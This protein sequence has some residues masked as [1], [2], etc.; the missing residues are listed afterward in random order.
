M[1]KDNKMFKE[2][3][4]NWPNLVTGI[5]LIIIPFYIASLI[6]EKKYTLVLFLIILFGD[7]LDGYLARKLK[8]TTHFGKL[9]DG[10]TDTIFLFSTFISITILGKLSL[11][12]L[13]LLMLPRMI[14]FA[15]E[16]YKRI[17]Y[18]KIVY[19]TSIYR[20]TAAVLNF[21]LIFIFILKNN[22]QVEALV[23]ILAGFLAMLLELLE[24]KIKN[25]K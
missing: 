22:I 25:K 8:Q 20:K 19:D 24:Q 2:K 11:M 16:S 13:I 3:I 9:F 4:V 17:I 7:F 12:Y 5:R 1:L 10:I 21:L 14:T 6:N 15:K 18:K 23:V